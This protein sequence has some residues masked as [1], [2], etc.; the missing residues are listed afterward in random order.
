MSQLGHERTHGV[1]QRPTTK[2]FVVSFFL[3]GVSGVKEI[4]EPELAGY[5]IW[6]EQ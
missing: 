2:N 5:E 6:T 3:Q 4:I 1:Q